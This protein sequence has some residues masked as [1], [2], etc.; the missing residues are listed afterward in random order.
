MHIETEYFKEPKLEFGDYFEHED[1]K[2][3]LAEYGPFGKNVVGFHPSEIKLGFIG[4]RETI[5][6][7]QEWIEKCSS[8]IES[9]NI[10]TIRVKPEEQ[11]VTLSEDEATYQT[12]RRFNKIIN[13]DFV[14]F[15]KE[16]PFQCEFQT[17]PLW[18]RHINPRELKRVLDIEPKQDRVLALAD[19]IE[20]SLASITQ[21]DPTPNIIII[22]LTSDMV[23]LADTVRISGN[24][25]LDL[26]REIK[27]RAMRQPTPIPVQLIKRRTIEGKRDVQEIAT[28]AWNFCT[29]Q[30]YKA[31]GIPWRPTTLEPDTCYIGI[32]F[33]VAQASDASLTMRSSVAQAFDYLGQG[34]V[35]RGEQ[36]K[37]DADKLGKMP[38]L[39]TERAKKLIGDILKEYIKIRGNPPS[40]VV[41]HKTSKFW[42]AERGE[43]NEIDGLYEGIESIFP[44]CEADFVALNQSGIRLF[45]EGNY[46]PLRG[47][48]FCVENEQ[49]F[50]YTMGF[51]PYLETYPRP[52]VPEPWQVIQHIGGS[53]PK[54]LLREVLVLTKMNVNNCSFADGTPIT[55]S[56]SHKVGEIM[57]HISE[58]GVIQSQYKFYM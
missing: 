36:F 44:S 13:R 1:S 16:S 7:A 47:T 15:N 57:K 3:G 45:R 55:L 10:E 20:D 37:W 4:T 52:Y 19:L 50:L 33:Y 48:Y 22:A 21:T 25:F 56:F 8:H 6:D 23:T 46:P 58:G 29:A 26:R 40:R 34:L 2:T 18:E 30:Y 41:I 12:L 27:A 17:N 42:G 14:G 11:E 35:L 39:T 5:S 28:R 38:H 43:H 53:S 51:I 32:S 54:E 24:F 49:H 9:E 31:G